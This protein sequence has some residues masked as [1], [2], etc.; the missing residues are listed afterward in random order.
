MIYNRK[1]F[2]FI[3]VSQE[4]DSDDDSDDEDIRVIDR[5]ENIISPAMMKFLKS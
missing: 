5:S 4:D 1:L 3:N 2:S